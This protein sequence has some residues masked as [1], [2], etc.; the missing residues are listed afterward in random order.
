[1]E[2]KNIIN[3]TFGEVWLDDELVG[4]QKGLQAK[5]D[6]TKEDIFMPRK[7][8][9]DTKIVS[10]EGKG[11]LRLYK[12]N[13]R[14]AIKLKELIKEGKDIRF[15]IIS[16]LADPDSYGAERVVLRGVSF[17]DLTLMDF[18]PKKVLEVETP[19]TFSDYDFLDE[20]QPK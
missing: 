11:T 10:W 4:E 6:F 12:V 3:G 20:I 19:F 13:S 2:A 7:L 17:D 5:I 18:E 16:K 14:M 8:G 15:T 1:M 9:K